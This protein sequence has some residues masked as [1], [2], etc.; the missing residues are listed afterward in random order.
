MARAIIK[1]NNAEIRV[2]SHVAR[3][4]DTIAESPGI[5]Y[6]KGPNGSGKTIFLKTLAGLNDINEISSTGIIIEPGDARRWF[7]PQDPWLITLGDTGFDE[8]RLVVKEN[9]GKVLDNPQVYRVLRKRIAHMSYG[10]RKII[11]IIKAYMIEPDIA[12]F[13]EPFSGLDK[14]YKGIAVQA[15]NDLAGKSL[16]VIATNKDAETP[17]AK[18]VKVLA[19]QFKDDIDPPVPVADKGEI[20]IRNLFIRRGDNTIEVG[21]LKLRSGEASTIIGPNGSGKTTTLLAI[22]GAIKYRGEI[23]LRGKTGF[24]PDDTLLVS[25]GVTLNDVILNLCHADKDCMDRSLFTLQELGVRDRDKPYVALSD[26][27]RRL[28]LLIPQLFSGRAVL[29]IDSWLEGI[30][31]RRRTVVYELIRQYLEDGGIIIAT[32]PRGDKFDVVEGIPAPYD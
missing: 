12:C 9:T 15:I 1:L 8:L 10:E 30:D 22:A 17:G 24:I 11:E 21:E 26:G 19:K 25:P 20:I 3:L 31:M 4:S 6:V 14:Q 29:L 32:L 7:V 18:E 27:Q 23:I 13:D 16:V 2:D 5:L 28:A